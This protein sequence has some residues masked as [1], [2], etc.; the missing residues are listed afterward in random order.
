MNP[1]EQKQILLP[2]RQVEVVEAENC[3]HDVAE[4]RQIQQE[5]SQ[6]FA[7]TKL[8]VTQGYQETLQEQ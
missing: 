6:F 8:E 2:T 4:V 7:E 1:L 5:R 3:A